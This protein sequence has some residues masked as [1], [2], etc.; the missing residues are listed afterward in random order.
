MPPRKVARKVVK[1]A[2][3]KKA[4]P[5]RKPW[6]AY[7]TSYGTRLNLITAH[8]DDAAYE[9]TIKGLRVQLHRD[10]VHVRDAVHGDIQLLDVVLAGNAVERQRWKDLVLAL[11]DHD[12]TQRSAEA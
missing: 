4:T 2:A 9:R 7:V 12:E 10:E 3:K 1:K 6:R 11:P 8:D 5:K